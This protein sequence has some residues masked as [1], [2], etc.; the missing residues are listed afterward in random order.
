MHPLNP[1]LRAF[2]RSTLPSQCA[3]AAHHVLLVP[4]TDVLLNARDR[5][6]NVSF[7]DLT[8]S[9]ED[10]LAS[11]VLRLQPGGSWTGGKDGGAGAGVGGGAREGKAKARQFTTANGKTVVV[12]D[13]TVYSNKGFK[14]I[15]QAQI[16]QDVLYYPDTIDAQQWLVHYI[17]K[18][19]VGFF[20]DCS[21]K[22]A[23]L[24][25]PSAIKTPAREQD[26]ET[27]FSTLIP[28]K[29]AIKS[30]SDLL[31]NFPLIAQQLQPGLERLFKEFMKEIEKPLPLPPDASSGFDLRPSNPGVERVE[32][33]NDSRPSSEMSTEH[34]E[35]RNGR[36]LSS[37]NGE[38]M[39]RQALEAAVTTAIDLFQMVDKQ[40]LSMLGASTD[41]TGP[42]VERLIERYVAEQLHSSYLFP[43]V[44]SIKKFDDAE[45]ESRIKQMLDIDVSQV[46]IPLKGGFQGKHELA[47]RLSKGVAEFR[48]MGVC[49]S[50]QEMMEVLL[51]T[52]RA[53]SERSD[54]KD[55]FRHSQISNTVSEKLTDV[56]VNADTLVAMLLI[57]VIRS[58]VRHLYARWAYMS[59]FIL[60]DDTESGE[61]GY[62]LSTFEAVLAYLDK[63]ADTLRKASRRN[64][65]LW[66]AAKRGDVRELR[67]LLEPDSAMNQEAAQDMPNGIHHSED[68][69][70]NHH[71]L[72]EQRASDW[73]PPEDWR[74]GNGHPVGTGFDEELAYSSS[75]STLAHVFP[76]ERTPSPAQSPHLLAKPK[77]KK[78]VSMQERSA[79]ISS[80]RSFRSRTTTTDSR[81]SEVR[82][83]IVVENVPMTH[84]ANGQSVIMMV[85][86]AGQLEALRY[87]LSLD[88]HYPPEMVL[89]DCSIDGTTI[90]SA[91][92][93]QGRRD[94]VT[95]L[96]DYILTHAREEDVRKYFRRQDNKGRCVAHYLFYYPELIQELGKRLPWRLKDNNG[97]TPL[98]AL[99]RSY[100]HEG[101]RNM[102]K[103]ALAA[104]TEYQGDGEPLHLD[105]HVDSRGTTLLH[106]VNDPAMTYELIHHCDSD[107]NAT[108]DK[109]FTPFMLASKY[110]RVDQVKILFADPR[111]D[112]LARDFRGLT[113]TELAKDDEV[114]NRIDDLVLLSAPADQDRRTTMIVRSFFVDDGTIRLVLKSAAPNTNSATTVTVTTCRRS[115]AEFEILARCLSTEN[116]A[117]WLPPIFS[118]RSPFVFPSKPSRSILRDIQ[119]RLDAFL[120]NLLS[121]STF[122]THELLWEFFLVPDLDLGSISQRSKA[123]AS[124][125]VERVKEEYPP[126]Q[127]PLRSQPS[128]NTRAHRSAPCITPR[129]HS[130]DGRIVFAFFILISTKPQ[131]SRPLRSPLSHSS[132]KPTK[133]LF[134]DTPSH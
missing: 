115:L 47:L 134:R 116:P 8:L 75:A 70:D 57:V 93:Q 67:N 12:K 14:H 121:H 38:N 43:A 103:S 95:Y 83:D 3:P 28:R 62:A 36:D 18:P 105:D 15:N 84:D 46:G 127:I 10:F 22:P 123:K 128:R 5:E 80:S 64:R 108:N 76:F 111:T 4:T 30:F 125:R 79:S 102:V 119:L 33:V 20:M 109:R 85:V 60:I 120:Q 91:A 132:L 98:F 29:K 65:R 45:L 78:R 42:L 122:S 61:A 88:Q 41:L 112:L 13:N 69:S 19:L 114:R 130:C 113:A 56:V 51:A 59:H 99:C 74:Y 81:E 104:A 68:A 54:S 87:L 107:V 34:L 44:C 126:S 25:N 118:F 2:F 63:D 77:L 50:P 17:S 66:Q 24:P 101:Y 48:K 58:P 1:F 117:S 31:N 129:V 6:T 94:I 97:Q 7:A 124:A 71:E 27:S 73:S 92:V 11:H 23:L 131:R 100:D 26:G 35:L 39:L 53:I 52:E 90:F 89:S 82:A 133:P 86:E 49:S 110:G 32:S 106:A 40:Q 37:N 72:E 9:S 21:V 16:L 55:S 96:L